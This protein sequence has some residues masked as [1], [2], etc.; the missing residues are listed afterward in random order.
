MST[1]RRVVGAAVAA[2]TLG[3]VLAATAPGAI[4]APAGGPLTGLVN[5]YIGTENFGN[6]FPGASAPFGMVQVS[7]DTGG[8]GGYDYKGSKIHGFS[9]THLSGVGCGVV[10]E[11]PIMP[12]TGAVTT[13][14][15][16]QYSSAF[17]HDDEQATPGYY[18]V[19][20]SRYDI[21]A[22]LTAT[23]RTGW[24]R[25]TFPADGQHNVLLNTGHA[26][27]AVQ[28]SSIQVVDDHTLTGSVT[29]GGFCAGHD[30]H[31]VHFVATF[32]TPFASY[33]TWHGDA[34]D[35]GAKTSSGDGN[36]GAWVTFGGDAKQVTVKVGLSYTGVAGATKN[37][38]AETGT[39]FDFDATRT[40]LT[41]Q[42]ERQLGLA[43][44]SG[45]THERQVAYYTSL[46]HALLHPNLSGDVD[47][48]YRGFDDKIH[49]AK[50]WTPRAN[51][52][53]W[54]TYRTQN[55]LLEL[56][57]PDV[58]RDDA[59]SLLAIGR[60]GGWLPRWALENSET[61]I[62]TG[63]PITPTLVE[64]WSKGFLA[65]H[66][67]E[68]YA[69][70]RKYATQLPPKDSQYNGRAGV[71]YYRKLGYIPSGLDQRTDC[72]YQGGD[73]DC[74]NPSSAT[75]EYSAADAAL[76]VMA[77]KLGH[78]KDATTFAQRG[79]WYRNLW[80]AR[81]Q[82]FHPR[83]ADG[84]FLSPFDPVS[85]NEQ[86]H[87]SGAYQYT[88]LVPQDPAGLVDLLGGRKAT[89]RRLDRF[90]A[91]D[92]LLADPAS[93]IEDEWISSPYD[94]YAK[95]TYNPNNEPDLIAPYFYT[96]AG[97]PAKAATVVRAAYRLFTTG[98]DGMTGNDDL[99]EMS[100]WYVMSSLGIY[101]TMS[102]SGTFVLSTPQ[103][104][105]TT[106]TIGRYGSRQGGTLRVTAPGV[107]D[108]DRYV[109]SV[110][111]DGASTSKTWLRFGSIA[112]G[113]TIDYRVS[114]TPGR[115]G[116]RTAD[117]PPSL[118]P[119]ADDERVT[120]AGTAM[121]A[122]A[123]TGARTVAVTASTVGQWPGAKIV[124]TA[125]TPPA[126]WRANPAHST[127]FLTS[128]GLPT[129]LDRTITL[130]VPK[131]TAAGSY[132]VTV[133]MRAYGVRTVTKTVTVELQDVT[134][135][136]GADCA[137]DLGAV[138]DLDGTATTDAPDSGNFDGG[139]WSYDAALLP[140]AGRHT[141]AGTSWLLPDPTGTA[142]NFVTARRQQ[143][144]VPAGAYAT[145]RVLG[146]A[147]GGALSSTVTATYTDGTSEEI[148]FAL[149]DWASSSPATGNSVAVAMAHR[150][151]TGQGVD[152]PPVNLFAV[153]IP[154]DEGKQLQS[155]TL[156]GGGTGEIY[157][158]TLAG[159]AGN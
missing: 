91:Y 53:L 65:G 158:V 71:E 29:D 116:T 19:G 48:K 12:T 34:L 75:L 51:F 109:S 127:K 90:F 126:G 24:Q 35:K 4:A 43:R 37:L 124:T 58:A 33:G 15:Y 159:N 93:T 85:G 52:S 145:A 131:G 99:G 27:M 64:L 97:A 140:A 119:T 117:A 2:V 28:T 38:R 142:K 17:S 125:V 95:S 82:Q 6:T 136:D 156:P 149:S 103:F 16:D 152:G 115:W 100:S 67:A 74:N 128:D 47:G 80:D 72:V 102:G 11:L 122:A 110:A 10:G 111:V 63:D 137:L 60:E 44:I 143:L 26:N 61:N 129:A 62:M 13:G 25:Y 55:Q 147:H 146:A 68:A 79:R 105:S 23:E 144:A 151:K 21:D 9:Q 139:G 8:Q 138:A 108:T 94:Y 133:T 5:P 120:F 54:D 132:P 87:E 49:A 84:S 7:P 89:E 92:K 112:H 88:W 36:R 154:L 118:D 39:G 41:A 114:A 46:Y 30:Q 1:V 141:A 106:V 73:S 86:F 96:S 123:A 153:G 107:S 150:I 121:G 113:G 20:L 130:D 101:P 50:G 81:I 22:E 45:G 83:N 157:A 59:L 40:A 98:P 57:R 134:C 77:R 78:A 69:L 18:R 155:L 148:P 42:W 70:L 104:P 14:D 66:E 135:A 56:L 31:T 3:G 32:S 76:S